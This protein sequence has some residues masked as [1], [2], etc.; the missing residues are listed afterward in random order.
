MSTPYGGNDPQQWAQQQPG[1]GGGAPQGTPSGGFPA[2]PPQQPGYPQQGGYPQQPAYDPN[3]QQGYPPQYGQQ[4]GGYP[5]QQPGY[6]PNQQQ[7][8]QQ[9]YDPNQQQYAQ[10]QQP[11]YPQTGP[12]PQYGQTAQ[13]D[14]QQQ[15]Y[16]G[17]P[18]PEGPKKKSGKGLWIGLGAVVVIA[19]VAV[20]LLV[21]PAPFNKKVFDNV[22]MQD[23][24]KKVL[25]DNYQVQGVEGVTCPESKEVKNGTGFDC[26]AKIGG[27]TKTV[28]IK[29]VNEEDGTY[30]VGTPK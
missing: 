12:Q 22:A 27:D 20:A 4:P 3:Q 19:L 26:E 15:G 8:Q 2:Q 6:D 14:F 9:P 29:V 23:A 28:P 1:Y 24:V 13:Y 5:Q 30:E 17:Q 7:Q 11:G 25:T 21:W 16:P 18:Q 10:P